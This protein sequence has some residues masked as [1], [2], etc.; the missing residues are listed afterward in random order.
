MIFI[1]IGLMALGVY[2]IANENKLIKFE[3]TLF[4]KIMGVFKK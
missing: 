3:R 4:S 2:T 1:C